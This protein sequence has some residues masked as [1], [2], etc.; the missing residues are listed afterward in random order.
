MVRVAGRFLPVSAKDSGEIARFIRGKKVDSAISYL[1]DVSEIKKAIPFKR[2]IRDVPHRKGK[3]AAGRFPKK[4]SEH[5]LKLLKNLKAN[6]A[7]KDL[8]DENLQIV[9]ASAYRGPVLHH[10]GRWIGRK[11][12]CTHVEIVAKEIEKPKEA[13]KVEKQI[14]KKVKKEEEPK[15]EVKI[16]KPAEKKEKKEKPVE[17][18]EVKKAA[19]KPKKETPKKPAEKVPTA[20]ELKE[21]KEKK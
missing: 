19:E 17:K 10:Y 2:H 7:D 12:K 8:D 9:H 5:F 1:T 4:A 15:K 14:E 18:K 13:K 20:A 3:M 21:K 11:R 16:K 6:A